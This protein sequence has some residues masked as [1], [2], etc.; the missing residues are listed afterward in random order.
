M[1]DLMA[2]LDKRLQTQGATKPAVRIARHSRSYKCRC[3]NPVFFDNTLCI[4]CGSTPG[5]GPDEGRAVALD[6]G[7]APGTWRLEGRTELDKLC[8]NRESP[9][10]CNWVIYA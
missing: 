1:Q 2:S 3:G 5:F 9:A 6:R 7:P 4:A 10:A 8:A